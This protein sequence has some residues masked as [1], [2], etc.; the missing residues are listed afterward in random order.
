MSIRFEE[1][2]LEGFDL[3]GFFE[4]LRWFELDFVDFFDFFVFDFDFDFL[5]LCFFWTFVF[6]SAKMFVRVFFRG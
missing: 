1:L 6:M 2:I 4:R 3:D 5:S